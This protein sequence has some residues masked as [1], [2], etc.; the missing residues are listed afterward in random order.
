MPL[1]LPTNSPWTGLGWNR[2]FCG[3]ETA[4]HRSA[5]GTRTALLKELSQ[6][7]P[8]GSTKCYVTSAHQHSLYTGRDLKPERPN[9]KHNCRCLCCQDGSWMSCM[10]MPEEEHNWPLLPCH[11]ELASPVLSPWTGLSCLVTLNR[12]LLSCH[13]ELASPALS[14]WTGLSCLV[15]LN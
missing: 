6:T 12:P 7:F 15:T 4:T 3:K 9:T 13:P 11:P 1:R 5:E 2:Y 8:A 10:F 14:P